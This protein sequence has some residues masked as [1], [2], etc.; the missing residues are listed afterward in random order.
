M[1]LERAREELAERLGS[2]ADPSQLEELRVRYL[3]RRSLVAQALAAVGQAPPADRPRLGRVANQARQAMMEALEAHKQ[4]L[5]AAE[6]ERRWQAEALDL[7]LPGRPPVLGRRHP[8]R[9]ILTEIEEIFLSMGF[10]I[11]AGPEVE[12]DHFN[13]ETLNIP[14]DHP[15]RDM[16]DS[17]YITDSMLLRTHTSPV[18]IRYMQAYAPRLPVRIIAPGRVFRR[19][20]DPTHSPVF[21]QVE[22]LLVDRGVSMAHL[23]GTLLAF[24]RRLFG[25]DT[26]TRLRPSFFPFTEPS[27]EVDVSCAVC[28]GS[29]CR[30]CGDSG[31]LEILGAGMVHPTVLRNGGYDPEEVSGFA[32]GM[33]VERVAMIRYVID[34]LRRFYEND[35]RFLEQ[36]E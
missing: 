36:F 10:A 5:L 2:T 31:W 35:L 25:P 21:H 11:A 23:N 32:F 4:R 16:Q 18:Q 20:D 34:D 3:G 15:A 7:T 33:G 27:V 26:R 30:V 19:D 29:G 17:F 28:G 22:G 12:W 24:A 8:L 13:F 9:I 6:R 14:R 1:Q